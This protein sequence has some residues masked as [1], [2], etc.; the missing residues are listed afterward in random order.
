MDRHA[1]FSILQPPVDL[2][3]LQ[4]GRRRPSVFLGGSIDNGA[5]EDWQSVLV[6]RL[7]DLPVTLLNP[8]AATW[9][10]TLAQD[11]SNPI[12]RAQVQW[13]ITHLGRADLRVFYFAPNSL[14]PITLMELGM[15]ADRGKACLVC[16]PPGYWRRG[17]VQVVCERYNIP[18][19]DDFDDFAADL[20]YRIQHNW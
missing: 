1:D 8:R 14:A 3:V 5:A 16:C 11:I 9:D 2:P 7:Q 15:F 20:R 17:N 13:E 6:E 10:P 19:H 18:L 12:F 4:I